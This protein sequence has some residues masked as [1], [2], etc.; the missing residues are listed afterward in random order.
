MVPVRQRKAGGRVVARTIMW[1]LPVFACAAALFL[2]L[3]AGRYVST[4]NAYV[5]GDRA[6]IA[7]ELSG[8]IV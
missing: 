7:T 1:L 5:K 3:T 6:S 2:W 4:D 8:P